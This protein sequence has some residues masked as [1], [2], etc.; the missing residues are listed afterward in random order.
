MKLLFFNEH[1]KLT[2]MHDDLEKRNNTHASG[3][4]LFK[5]LECELKLLQLCISLADYVHTRATV[6]VINILKGSLL[7]AGN[8]YVRNLKTCMCEWIEGYRGGDCEYWDV[9]ACGLV[10]VYCRFRGQGN[11]IFRNFVTLIPGYTASH[12]T[13]QQLFCKVL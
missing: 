10:D 2:K 1:T 8:L 3:L 7:T 12:S 11:G 9:A 4:Q 13:I 6:R 5:L